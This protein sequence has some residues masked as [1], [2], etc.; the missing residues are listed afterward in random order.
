MSLFERLIMPIGKKP[1]SGLVK[2]KH[3]DIPDEEGEAREKAKVDAEAKG[4]CKMCTVLSGC[5]FPSFNMPKYPQHAF[6]DCLLFSI[7]K[8]NSETKAEC[9]LEK[10]TKYIFIPENSAGK[11]KLFQDLGFTIEDS[12]YLKREFDRQANQKYLS[13]DYKLG[14]LN[15][16]GQRIT[17]EIRLKSRLKDDI[18][19][20]TGW[21]IRP[22]GLITCNTPLGG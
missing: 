15:E 5:Y 3:R 4:H 6:C 16:H 18:I 13:G 11:T 19:L 9:A 17:I 20:K 10:F 14:K 1:A 21:M 22:L 7:S 2:W 12:G 8:S